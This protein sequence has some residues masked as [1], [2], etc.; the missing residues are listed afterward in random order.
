MGECN[1]T[2]QENNINHFT[3]EYKMF[4]RD[5]N[6]QDIVYIE[7]SIITFTVYV[8]ARRSIAFSC[9]KDYSSINF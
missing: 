2:T 6:Y 4:Y 5:C 1:W 3:G 7:F 8:K 9:G